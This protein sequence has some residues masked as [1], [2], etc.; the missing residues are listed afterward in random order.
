MSKWA[1]IC[2]ECGSLWLNHSPWAPLILSV[3]WTL[4]MKGESALWASCVSHQVVSRHLKASWWLLLMHKVIFSFCCRC[5]A[6]HTHTHPWF[7]ARLPITA[8]FSH[9]I[10]QSEGKSKQTGYSRCGF[11]A[12]LKNQ[13]RLK[14]KNKQTRSRR[15]RKLAKVSFVTKSEVWRGPGSA[16]GSLILLWSGEAQAGVLARGRLAANKALY[17]ASRPLTARAPGIMTS[18]YPS[19]NLEYR[20]HFEEFSSNFAPTSTLAHGW[21][22]LFFE[23]KGQDP[24]DLVWATRG[25]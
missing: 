11:Q 24:C 2:N 7:E 12:L 5:W 21:A 13:E 4:H 8:T 9:R 1:D 18:A 17:W 14:T 19:V 23:V 25:S 6:S 20:E 10:S 16:S 22:D 15:A 3:C